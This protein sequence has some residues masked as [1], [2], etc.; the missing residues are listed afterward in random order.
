MV[1]GAQAH[2]GDCPA[3]R[4]IW[5]LSWPGTTREAG[6]EN[7]KTA[8]RQTE[9]EIGRETREEGTRASRDDEKSDEKEVETAGK[10]RPGNLESTRDLLAGQDSRSQDSTA[11]ATLIL[12]S[13]TGMETW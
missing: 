12:Q 5:E 1:R 3:R 6:R 13:T 2:N 10:R 9:A 7:E 8:D 11:G 4:L